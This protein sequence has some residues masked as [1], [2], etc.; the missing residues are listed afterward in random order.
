MVGKKCVKNAVVLVPVDNIHADKRMLK[1]LMLNFSTSPT[2]DNNTHIK[3]SHEKLKIVNF[4][5]SSELN[6]CAI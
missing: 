6:T 4:Y 1:G 3:V 2:G 5:F